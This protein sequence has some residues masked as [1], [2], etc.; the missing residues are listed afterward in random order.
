MGTVLSLAVITSASA[1]SEG[2]AR[3]EVDEPAE[4]EITAAEKVRAKEHFKRGL[5][6]LREEAWAPALAEFLQSRELFPT[7]V[8]TNNAAVALR[9]LQRGSVM[10]MVNG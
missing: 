5:R 3:V 7:R 10:G 9:K 2:E 4:K 6:L 8:A 1:Q